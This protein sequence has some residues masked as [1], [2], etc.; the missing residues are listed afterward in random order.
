[1]KKRIY[2]SHPYGGMKANR[3]RAA[4]LARMYRELW[5]SEGKTDWEI[6]NPIEYFAPIA[7]QGVDDD[8]RQNG[9]RL[10][11]FVHH[12]ADDC[13]TDQHQHHVILELCGDDRPKLRALL[14]REL[15]AAVLLKPPCGLGR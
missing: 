5:D 8:D 1:M 15:V 3:E 12:R 2:L 11:K 6:V 4:A 13:R 7:E 10:G 9:K 14:L